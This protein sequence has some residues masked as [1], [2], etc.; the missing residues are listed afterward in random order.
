MATLSRANRTPRR[1]LD[2]VGLRRRR[3][4]QVRRSG[5]RSQGRAR[6]RSRTSPTRT[7]H[8]EWWDQGASR[9]RRMKWR[10]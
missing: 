1:G 7:S 8:R 6:P 2:L 3:R 9:Q 5:T 10:L 4:S